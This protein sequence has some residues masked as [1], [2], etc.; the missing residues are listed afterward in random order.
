LEKRRWETKN[1]TEKTDTSGHCIV[2]LVGNKKKIAPLP[3]LLE[4]TPSSIREYAISRRFFRFRFLSAGIL[5][6]SA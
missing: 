6:Y 4:K 3:P 5:R 2:L 1:K